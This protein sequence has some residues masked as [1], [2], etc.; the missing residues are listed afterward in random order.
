[1]NLPV[2][3]DYS[4]SDALDTLKP[5]RR[6]LAKY[7]A[8]INDLTALDR[9]MSLLWRRSLVR[10]IERDPETRLRREMEATR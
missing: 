6:R 8:S 3:T 10:S 4:H 7:L 5:L 1:M 9:A 2:I